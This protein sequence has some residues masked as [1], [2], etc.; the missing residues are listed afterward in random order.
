MDNDT[1]AAPERAEEPKAEPA[2]APEQTTLMAVLAY[3]G[4]LVIIPFL[5]AKD[6]PFVKFHIKQGLILF[7][8]HVI[9]WILHPLL[10]MYLGMLWS[11]ISLLNLALI[12]LAVIGIVNVV[13]KR[14]KELPVVGQFSKYFTF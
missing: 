4:P 8:G 7:V 3:I 14:E 10:G 12:V 9:L 11:L 13:Q 6:D 2:K 5:V 1:Q